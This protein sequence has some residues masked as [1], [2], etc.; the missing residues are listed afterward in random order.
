MRIAFDATGIL[1]RMSRNRGIGNYSM[2]QFSTMIERDKENEYFFFNLFDFDFSLKENLKRTEHLEEFQLYAGKNNFLLDDDCVD[3]IRKIIR[4]FLKEKQIDVFC[5][6]SPFDGN[7]KYQAEWF[8]GVKLIAVVYDIIPF[9]FKEHYFPEEG[10]IDGYM[11]C[12]EFLRKVDRIQVISQS[13]KDDLIKYLHFPAEKIDVIW[14]A[15]DK[16]YHIADVAEEEKSKLYHKFGIKGDF[17]MCTGGDDERKNIAG[18]IE[19]YSRINPKIRQKYQLVIV[20]KLS[21]TSIERYQKLS[22]ELGC[23]GRVILTNFVSSEELLQF[24]NLATLMAFPSTYE[25]FGLPIVEAW[26]CGTP[27]LTSNNSS[28]VQIAGDGAVIVNPFDIDDIVRGL[29]YALTECDLKG[30]LEKGREQLKKF[31]WENVADACISSINLLK[32]EEKKKDSVRKEDA[33]KTIA[34]FTPLPPLQ[35]GISDY[36]V[37]IIAELSAYFDI[38][39]FIDDHYKGDLELGEHVNILNHKKYK[40]QH[41]KY[42]DT[43]YQ[44]GNSEF[45]MYMF[46]YVRE[47]PGTVV[48]HDYNLYGIA[49]HTCFASSDKDYDRFQRILSEDYDE[50]AVTEYI[51]KLK[52]GQSGYKV[53]NMPLNGFVT[54]YAKKIIVHSNEA[55]RKLLEKDI[56]RNICQIWHYAK[57]E[58]KSEKN[59]EIKQKLGYASSD[60]ILAAF[61]H[62]HET[63]RII[64]ILKAFKGLIKENDNLKLLFV[65]K[66][67][68]ELK[69][70]FEEFVKK[71]NLSEKVRVTGYIELDEFVHYID[72]TDICLNLRYPY[73]GETSGS[74]MR[75][76]AKGKCVI[77]NDIGSFG[78]FPD[79]ACIKIPSVETMD[80]D[81]E[82]EQICIAIRRL[83]SEPEERERISLNAYEF[84]KEN[85]DIHI[86]GKKYADFINAESMERINEEDIARVSSRLAEMAADQEEINKMS[87]ALVYLM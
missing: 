67:D 20:C 53:F 52:G 56:G 72:L 34:F 29:N 81:M 8:E 78:E 31:Q 50:R 1:G 44:I 55:K 43:I 84:A 5:V 47:Y 15:V 71:E 25:G 65:G 3:I 17:I 74:L 6:T 38:D 68:E 19:A 49:Y 14:G 86:V 37:D 45:H 21:P 12:I 63:K 80:E 61:G 42:T 60:C 46:P 76:F 87:G 54:N 66:L 10:S 57:V 4:K 85:L 28:L 41:K 2:G 48:L 39:V 18:L 26:A 27:V 33:R 70:E 22:L 35:S 64:P 75:I 30:L 11:K 36:S 24:Y 69:D 7:A 51:A 83:L 73:N 16:R 23:K 9:I 62:V 79:D 77:V 58:E 82:V 32:G 59:D 40:K 13:A